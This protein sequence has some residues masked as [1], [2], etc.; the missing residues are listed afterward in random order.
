MGTDKVEVLADMAARQN[1]KS[2]VQP[3]SPI[4]WVLIMKKNS[5][6]NFNDLADKYNDN[7]LVQARGG[8]IALNRKR[9][10]LVDNL[11]HKLPATTL[12]M[13]N[14][15]FDK[16]RQRD[17]AITEALMEDLLTPS[18]SHLVY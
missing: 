18:E 1:V 12:S 13:I 6:S 10:W 8:D 14:L 11:L 4:Q 16:Y 7:P 17:A 9:C 15:H 2:Q 3:L 5:F